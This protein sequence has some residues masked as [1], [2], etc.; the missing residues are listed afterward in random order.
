MHGINRNQQW[1]MKAALKPLNTLNFNVL[2]IYTMYIQ[3]LLFPC[4]SPTPN[5]ESFSKGTYI[6]LENI[7][8]SI[9]YYLY[10]DSF[11]P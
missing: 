4:P 9:I 8:R 10:I 11:L 7:S 6:Y 3:P 2:H 1:Q 5:P